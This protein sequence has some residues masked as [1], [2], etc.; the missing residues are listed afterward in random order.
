VG[1]VGCLSEVDT[2]GDWPV[3]STCPMSFNGLLVLGAVGVCCIG[4]EE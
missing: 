2:D 1:V 4:F 3:D